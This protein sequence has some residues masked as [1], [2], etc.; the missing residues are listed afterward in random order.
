MWMVVATVLG[1]QFRRSVVWCCRWPDRRA[2]VRQ[3]SCEAACG[4]ELGGARARGSHIGHLFAV[5]N[6]GVGTAGARVSDA[7][8]SSPRTNGGFFLGDARFPVLLAACALA[9]AL[10]RD[11]RALIIQSCIS[12]CSGGIFLFF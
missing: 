1:A 5:R 3:P 9:I 4:G 10:W 2:A 11:R 8:F 7:F 6:E 12:C